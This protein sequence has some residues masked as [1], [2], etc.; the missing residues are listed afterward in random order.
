LY[1][2]L[3]QIIARRALG[4]DEVAR[5]EAMKYAGGVVEAIVKRTTGKFW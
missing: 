4:N 3:E 2:Q 1:E 5:M